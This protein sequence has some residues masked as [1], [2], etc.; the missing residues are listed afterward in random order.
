MAFLTIKDGQQYGPYS[1][2]E[3]SRYVEE[4]ALLLTDLCWQEGWVEWQ[5]LSSVVS[6]TPPLSLPIQEEP[7]SLALA[8][9]H[10]KGAETILW[11]GHAN[12]WRYAGQFFWSL[13]FGI[14]LGIFTLGIGLLI[15]PLWWWLIFLERK[16]RKYIVSNKRVRTEFGLLAKSSKEIRVRDIRSVNLVKKGLAGLFGIGT[17]EFSSAGGAGVEISFE[18]I[19]NAEKVKR[20][21]S[22]LQDE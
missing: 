5:P 12:I 14:T 2:E 4:G 9:R 8:E 19:E 21:V 20:L 3:V 15:L 7:H 13:V 11:Q 1:L 10:R 16:K 22:D 6:R 18:A 17:L